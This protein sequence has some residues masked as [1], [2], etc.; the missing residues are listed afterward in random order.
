METRI[1]IKTIDL[2]SEYMKTPVNDLYR[3]ILYK[4]ISENTNA[5]DYL[6][7]QESVLTDIKTVDM[8]D[9]QGSVFAGIENDLTKIA[10]QN[11]ITNH[12]S[13]VKNFTIA[14]LIAMTSV[15]AYFT[16]VDFLNNKNNK[17][18]QNNSSN[19]R[20]EQMPQQ[21]V[22]KKAVSLV[23]KNLTTNFQNAQALKDNLS[24]IEND[25]NKSFKGN[26]DVYAYIG[27]I[28]NYKKIDD[29]DRNSDMLLL[30][31]KEMNSG[32]VDLD[33][34]DSYISKTLLSGHKVDVINKR[35]SLAMDIDSE[36]KK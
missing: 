20:I 31:E 11:H 17:N 25:E 30:A 19:Q 4:K 8:P 33:K 7:L 32:V 10:Q 26:E 21:T 18:I 34:V 15:L 6:K 1:D 3:D 28:K 22:P 36:E 5:L 16:T 12:F 35:D 9:M 23:S 24:F 13:N 29:I 27:D 2:I 14:G